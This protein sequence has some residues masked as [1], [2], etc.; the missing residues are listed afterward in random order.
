MSDLVFSS[1]S[2]LLRVLVV[3]P[4]AYT[5]LVLFLRISGKRTLT[6]LN[7]FDLVVTV[8]LGSTLGTIL[9]D[10]SVP[11]AEGLLALALLVFLQFAIAWLSVRSRRFSELVK[12]EP[13]LIAHKGRFLDGALVQQ[14]VNREEVLAVVRAN[15]LDGLEHAEAVVLETDGS[16]SV[17]KQT[18]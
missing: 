12:S 17:I 16:I 10:K 8:A 6:K 5:A 18:V 11:L 4:L 1:W 9:L 3:G 2:G 13:T 14:R 7:A 15:G